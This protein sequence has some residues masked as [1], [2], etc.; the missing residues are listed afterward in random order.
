MP[1]VGLSNDGVGM[2]KA[3][4]RGGGRRG[5]SPDK[6]DPVGRPRSFI[7]TRSFMAGTNKSRSMAS[8]RWATLRVAG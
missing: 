1:L 6:G 7:P 5:A 4:P 8:G 2:F 3:W